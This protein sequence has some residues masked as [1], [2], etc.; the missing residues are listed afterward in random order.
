[1][2]AKKVIVQLARDE[3]G[4]QKMREVARETFEDFPEADFVEV[5]EHAGWFLQWNRAEVCVGTAN[6]AAQLSNESHEWAKQFDGI[7]LIAVVRRD[8]GSWIDYVG[9]RPN[10][11]LGEFRRPLVADRLEQWAESCA[12]V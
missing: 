11:P 3:W 1:M 2:K 8:T 5:S 7:D 12:S 9:H 4:N 6:D 10:L